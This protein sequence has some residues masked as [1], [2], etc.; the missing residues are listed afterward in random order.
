MPADKPNGADARPGDITRLFGESIGGD[1][2][3]TDRLFELIYGDL[4][5]RAHGFMRRER[6][7]ITLQTTALIHEAYLSMA[8]QSAKFRNRNQFLAIAAI[9][10]KRILI[11][12]ARARAAQKRGE[13]PEQVPLGDDMLRWTPTQ[14]EKLLDLDDALRELSRRLPR[15]AKTVDLRFFG[16]MSER[17]VSEFLGVSI[18]TVQRDWDFARAYLSHRMDPKPHD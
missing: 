4:K 17:E 6:Q 5:K 10:M 9:A 1:P 8:P 13:R 18:K 14:L 15:A 7:P 11:G 16:G 2:Q 3:S 12:Q